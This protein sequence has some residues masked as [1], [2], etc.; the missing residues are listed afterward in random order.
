MDLLTRAYRGVRESYNTGSENLKKILVPGYALNPST[1]IAD[2]YA[3]RGQGFGV[4]TM[5]PVDMP[6]KE[7]VFEPKHVQ[8][9][10]CKKMQT[11]KK[12]EKPVITW[13]KQYVWHPNEDCVENPYDTVPSRF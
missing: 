9:P 1:G 8:I 2:G 12:Q 13:K 4:D 10:E 7:V 3:D 6:L 5:G 11:K